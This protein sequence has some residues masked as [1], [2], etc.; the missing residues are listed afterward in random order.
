MPDEAR[1][2]MQPAW[3]PAL[4]AGIGVAIAL[5][6][7]VAIVLSWGTLALALAVVW[8]ALG[9]FLV[10]ASRFERSGTRL[11]PDALTVTEGRRPRRLTRP[12]ILDLRAAGPEDHPWRL[13]AVL[14]DGELVPLLGVP[15]AEL[16]RLRAWHVRR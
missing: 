15:P 11:T 3:L 9:V 2:L 12:D 10:W 7:V 8:L 14:R 16:G 4:R 6:A 13:E 5:S 1:W